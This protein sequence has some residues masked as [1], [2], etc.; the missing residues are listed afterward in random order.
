M[1]DVCLF[2][3]FDKDGKVD[4]HVLQYLEKIK[5]LNFSIVFISAA[6]LL[7][8]DIERLCSHCSDVILRENK[9][10]DFGSWAAGFEKHGSAINGRLMLVNDSV[11]GP[12]GNLATALA[13]VTKCPA[14]FYGFVESDDIVPHLQSWFLLF[15]S[16][17]VRN[18][19]FRAILAQPFAEM[20][21]KQIIENGEIGLTRRLVAAGFRYH[22]L[23]R[24]DLAGFAVHRRNVNPMHLFWHELLF[25][26][27]VPF[28]KVELL[29]DNP[30]GV[31]DAKTILQAVE[32]IDPSLCGLM[33][34]HLTR[35]TAKNSLNRPHDVA[36]AR[37]VK[38]LW[39]GLLRKGYR[40]KRENRRAAGAWNF[41]KLEILAVVLRVWRVFKSLRDSRSGR[42]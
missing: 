17:I 35:T 32:P 23:Y 41:I 12:V 21:K 15:E 37:W 6:P 25:D 8:P 9:G 30:I 27:G 36:L 28:L 34:L 38:G 2:A 3:H 31:E 42:E 24:I 19:E 39:Y 11:Y 18:E 1:Q 26:E 33:K 14:D 20:T 22:A 4:E 29:R 13:R 7:Q 5:D 16:R 40:L 10:L